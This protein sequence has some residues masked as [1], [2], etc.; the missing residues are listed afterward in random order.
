MATAVGFKSLLL[1]RRFI[2]AEIFLEPV[3]IALH[4]RELHFRL[5]RIVRLARQDDHPDRDTLRL[6]RVVKFVALRDRDTN[7]G[8]VVLDQGRSRNALNHEHR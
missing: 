8:L 2:T 3:E 4:Q 6:E 5:V 7:I 1:L